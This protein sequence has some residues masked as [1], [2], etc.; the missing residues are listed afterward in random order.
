[1]PCFLGNPILRRECS[2][3]AHRIG[4]CQ[5]LLLSSVV[6]FAQLRAEH[7]LLLSGTAEVGTD[8]ASGIL[9][10]TQGPSASPALIRRAQDCC[11][12]W[13]GASSMSTSHP[14]TSASM[15]Y[16]LS[17]LPVAPPPLA[18]L[19]LRLRPS[20]ALSTPSAALRGESLP[21]LAPG[22]PDPDPVST[23]KPD[24]AWSPF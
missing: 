3:L 7:V 19:T 16:P 2:L 6:R 15:R 21:Q 14:C 5:R 18:L 12:H 24:R 20:R 8:E 1:M 4:P 11:T 10:G 22:Y 9:P 13:S 17:T 23:G